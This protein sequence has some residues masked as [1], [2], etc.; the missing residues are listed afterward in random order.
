MAANILA[1]S[2]CSCC[3]HCSRG[4]A[5]VPC[6]NML[7]SVDE[8]GHLREKKK[9]SCRQH[10]YIKV[11]ALCC[12]LEQRSGIDIISSTKPDP[13]YQWESDKLIVRHHKREPRGQPFLSR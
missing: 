8:R 12:V 9:N 6:L 1:S 10:L 4:S 5:F 11:I 7:F 2:I 3:S 13:E